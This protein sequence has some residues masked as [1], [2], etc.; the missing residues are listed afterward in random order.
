MVL[1]WC[2]MKPD[3]QALFIDQS[4]GFGGQCDNGLRGS[5]KKRRE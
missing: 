4:M 3:R 5:V 2:Q 1:S